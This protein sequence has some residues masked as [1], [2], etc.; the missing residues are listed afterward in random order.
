MRTTHAALAAGILLVPALLG[1]PVAHAGTASA[2]AALQDVKK[3]LT[4]L[5]RKQSVQL[6]LAQRL[7][8]DGRLRGVLPHFRPSLTDA[9]A[10]RVSV[11]VLGAVTPD[12]LAALGAHGPVRFA[13]SRAG[14]VHT[15]LPLAAVP[16]IAARADVRKVSSAPAMT[17]ERAI[18]H[19]VKARV[20]GQV[21]SEGD[22]THQA[23]TART[24]YGV[25]GTGVKVCVIS[26]GIGS[27][28]AS[29]A[30][31]ELPATVEVLP[32]QEGEGDEGTAMLEIVHDLAP[33][34]SL[35]FATAV[36]GVH[37]LAANI[38]A[39]REQLR[40]DVLVDDV[41][42]YNESP[43]QDGPIAQAVNDVTAAG[44]LY[45]SSA[46]NNGNKTAGT[47]GHWEGDFTDSGRTLGGTF[48]TAHD[49][50][51]G[52]GVQPHNPVSKGSLGAPVTLF[53]SDPL[54]HATNDFDLYVLDPS[55]NV[56]AAGIE[57]QTGTEDPYEVTRIPTSDPSGFAHPAPYFIAVTRYGG[58]DPRYLSLS[59]NGGRFTSS[60]NLTGYSTPGD[61][62]GHSAA[63][64]AVSVAAAPAGP[65]LKN[66]LEPGD[67][68]NPTGPHPN[69][70]T[71]G[72]AT[73]R[74]TSDGP[75]R[76][77]YLADG[78]PGPAVRNKP[79]LTAADGVAT[80]VPGFER[81]FGTSAAAPHAAAIAALLRQAV[82]AA[83]PARIRAALTG[84]ALDTG[85]PGHD[86]V[87]GHGIVMPGPALAALGAKPVT[88]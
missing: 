16:V 20:A 13:D 57:Q 7:R 67:P 25:D 3:T 46:G 83:T 64:D 45:F 38:R 43:F 59:L 4:P 30:A 63:S 53:W 9:G 82:P 54:G 39:L 29:Q 19:S 48:G 79:D 12:L 69:A 44:A 76:V 51:P 18:T 56:V 73:E 70:F 86:N 2:V 49:F 81:F 58:T 36:F 34:A 75:R 28:A 24:R 8:A 5:E 32:G 87:S 33:G 78:R 35:G 84:S 42:Y 11:D 71:T 85:A 52:P 68:D 40:C 66:P 65:A 62:Q 22:T 6:V 72:S 31:G 10:G 26:D 41:R 21:R 55:G 88:P 60:D 14:V 23:D 80:S 37:G 1:A 15:D 61:T 27:L 47:S 77:F 74:F 50:N 17:T